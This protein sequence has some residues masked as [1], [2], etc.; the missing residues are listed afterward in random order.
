MPGPEI[1]ENCTSTHN[2]NSGDDKEGVDAKTVQ[3]KLIGGVASLELG[4]DLIL[5]D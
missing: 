2:W 4:E 1:L 5:D 3:E